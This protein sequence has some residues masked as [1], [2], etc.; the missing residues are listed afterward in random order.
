MANDKHE[1]GSTHI[2]GG[3]TNI[4]GDLVGGNKNSGQ[5]VVIV[6][7]SDSGGRQS[8]GAHHRTY[9]GSGRN[10][11]R[12]DWDCAHVPSPC[13]LYADSGNCACAN[14]RIDH[15]FARESSSRSER[16]FC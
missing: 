8:V 10:Y 15:L 2:S 11:R 12:L 3:E 13:A 9:W 16:F 4:E 14:P 7:D 1:P 5:N 6:R